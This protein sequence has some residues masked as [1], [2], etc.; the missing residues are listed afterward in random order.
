MAFGDHV[1]LAGLN[2]I[3]LKRRVACPRETINAMRATFRLGI[4]RQ[5]RGHRRSRPRGKSE[6][7]SG[8]AEV[9]GG[10]ADFILAEAKQELV[11]GA[12]RRG[13]S[14]SD[15]QSARREAVR[16]RDQNTGLDRGRRRT[17]PCGGRGSARASGRAVFVV[18]LT[19][20][21]TE[22]WVHDFPHEFHSPGEPGRIIKTLKAAGA[23]EVLLAGK[24][25]RPKFSEMKLDAKGMLLLPKAMAAAKKG[26]DAL[27]RFIVGIC[28][29]EGLKA[30]SVAEAAPALVACE[31]AL[32]RITPG[33]E[34]F[35][36]HRAGLADRACAGCAGCGS[37]S[38]GVR[39]PDLE[40]GGRR[41][42][43]RHAG[44][45]RDLA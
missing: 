11:P 22:D 29:D 41:R 38:G 23:A 44:A 14:M 39:R 7:F 30:D 2:L 27:L 21:L 45:Y 33:E 42:H 6:K 15:R 16:R 35:G 19:G 34:H 8:I 32:G 40:C 3:G 9:A 20:S 17:A 5:R 31:G 13:V 28:E 36:R 18:P 1:E 12:G 26:D 25:D 24:V 37:G 4:L 43:R 10:I